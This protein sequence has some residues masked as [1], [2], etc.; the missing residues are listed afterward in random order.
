MKIK[1]FAFAAFVL[2]VQTQTM[3][4][5]TIPPQVFRDTVI[6]EAPSDSCRHRGIVCARPIPPEQVGKYI[7]V[8]DG[9]IHEGMVIDAEVVSGPVSDDPVKIATELIE[10]TLKKAGIITA[11]SKV[12]SFRILPGNLATSIYPKYGKLDGALII[13]TSK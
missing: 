1:L 11:E 10:K 12:K 2:L 5:N 9:T 13:T 3:A 7:W 6:V 8:V 4:T